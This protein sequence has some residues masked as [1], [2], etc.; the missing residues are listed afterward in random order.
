MLSDW[1][2]ATA[3]GVG[4]V[5]LMFIAI[6]LLASSD[7]A[8][9]TPGPTATAAMPA[10]ESLSTPTPKPTPIPEPEGIDDGTFRVGEE[11]IP[12]TYVA[13]GMSDR[14]CYWARLSGFSGAIEDIIENGVSGGGQVIVEI[15]ATDVGFEPQACGHWTRLP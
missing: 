9:T 2:I 11:I 1:R 7:E 6:G 12:G 14:A 3:V 15:K 13:P 5:L 8:A 10:P 4:L